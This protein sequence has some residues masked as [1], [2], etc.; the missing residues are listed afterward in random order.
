MFGRTA[1]NISEQMITDNAAQN[2]TQSQIYNLS[3]DIIKTPN[4]PV[5]KL[6]QLYLAKS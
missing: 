4:N 5:Q 3:Q 6:Q 2:A 1:L